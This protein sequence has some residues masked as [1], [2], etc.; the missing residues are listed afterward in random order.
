MARAAR[1]PWLLKLRPDDAAR[2]LARARAAWDYLA[3]RAPFGALCYHFYGCMG[4]V[5]ATEAVRP[6][7]E[8]A[9]ACYDS[10]GDQS[11]DERVWAAVELYAATG[12]AAFHSYFTQRHCPRYRRW[13]WQAL[14]FSYGPATVAYAQLAAAA[15][16]GEQGALAVD[17]LVA[18]RCLD[19]LAA[20]AR[21]HME[22]AKSNAYRLAVPARTFRIFGYGW[23]YPAEPA[24]HLLLAAAL[25]G[26]GNA[27][28]A[29]GW[30]ALAAQ[31]LHYLLGANPQGFSLISGLGARRYQNVVDEESVYDDIDPAWPGQSVGLASGFSWINSYGSALGAAFP[32]GI[33][34]PA[35]HRISDVFNVNTEFTVPIL[36]MTLGAV[37]ALA[38]DAARTPLP[39]PPNITLELSTSSG[40]APLSVA[41]S[42]F[43]QGDPRVVATVEYDFG[44]GGHSYQANPVHVY[45]E[46]GR[47]LYGS[48]TVVDRAGQ[49]VS[50]SFT[51]F[52]CWPEGSDPAPPPPS[53]LLL[54]ARVAHEADPTAW[55]GPLPPLLLATSL[56]E[57]PDDGGASVAATASGTIVASSANLAWQGVQ[58]A[59]QGAALRPVRYEDTATY[60]LLPAA[61]ATAGVAST[62]TAGAT[63]GASAATAGQV[64]LGAASGGLVLEAWLYVEKFLSYGRGN[65]PLLGIK[66]GTNRFFGL[67]GTIWS[68][69]MLV[70]GQQTLANDT[71]LA[72]RLTLGRWHHLK[73]SATSANASTSTSSNT[74][75]SAGSG[76]AQGQAQAFCRAWVDGVL[77]ARVAGCSSEEVFRYCGAAAGPLQLIV[78]S[79]KGYVDGLRVYAS[80][81]GDL[82]RLCGPRPP[83]PPPPRPPPPPAPDNRFYT[84]TPDRGTLALLDSD[85]AC[86]LT[87]RALAA[88]IPLR[89]FSGGAPSGIVL[90]PNTTTYA[91]GLSASPDGVPA[92][93]N[94]SNSSSSS[95]Q[96]GEV[97][98]TQWMQQPAGCS[99]R[100]GSQAVR[101]GSSGLAWE[102]PGSI[103]AAARAA[104]E[105][106]IDAKIFVEAWRT[107]YSLWNA[108][109]LGI[110]TNW[111]AYFKISYDMWTHAR[112]LLS[113][114]ATTTTAA[115]SSNSSTS[116]ISALQAFAGVLLNTSQ[117]EAA[118]S[119]GCWHHVALTAN[120]SGCALAVDGVELVAAAGCN[121]T[122][123]LPK[124]AGRA[125]LAVG[126]VR[127]WVDELRV[128]AVWRRTQRPGDFQWSPPPPPPPP[129]PP[130]LPS[131]PSPPR[132]PAPRPPPPPP[133]PKPRSPSPPPPRPPLPPPPRPPPPRPPP[134]SLSS[135]PPKPLP[136]TPPRPSTSPPPP[137]PRPPPRQPPQPSP[138]SAPHPPSPAPLPPPPSPAPP[139][140]PLPPAL[141]LLDSTTLLLLGPSATSCSAANITTNN[142]A[143]A[144]NAIAAAYLLSNSSS[145]L[146]AERYS[147]G[148][149]AGVLA[150]STVGSPVLLSALGGVGQPPSFAGHSGGCVLWLNHSSCG[151]CAY[152]K[153]E[154][155]TAAMAAVKAAG[156]MTID[157]KL[158]VTKWVNYAIDNS[159]PLLGW[160]QAWDR[161]FKLTSDKYQMVRALVSAP[162]TVTTQQGLYGGE[163]VKWPLLNP[164]LSPGAWH[165]VALTVNSSA[166]GLYVDGA[167]MNGTTVPCNVTAMAN[168]GSVATVTVGGFQGYVADLRLSAGWGVTSRPVPL[169]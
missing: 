142:N 83:P 86:G 57:G 154:V 1:S 162:S 66:Q 77:V 26:G 75:S 85:S 157:A 113:T 165:H 146:L 34:Y 149:S 58:P 123:L 8:K 3:A 168:W 92:S 126:G 135:P 167:L 44:D 112:V 10:K 43:I 136:P 47:A 151:S 56:A 2:Y 156:A 128:S 125:V 105:F 36:A 16:S 4:T 27:S 73:L 78:G 21:G 52:T 88:A 104:G 65:T 124:P 164:A 166:C 163:F 110:S 20:V 68:G 141:S 138:P 119:A 30:R 18:Q 55:G 23:H 60:T 98:N 29:A 11:H 159:D 137:P 89:L 129:P 108:D 143:A 74:S 96:A 122:R 131:P 140:P 69:N 54:A 62:A 121:A 103:L 72:P 94:S 12:E 134:Q 5:D 70:A 81:D 46:A 33:D 161:Y 144:T 50:K 139:L 150:P 45:G 152:V 38:G 13:G 32:P 42:L 61:G 17:P 91:A 59:W 117:L 63:A 114:P 48:V 51:V 67:Q 53:G 148:M 31:Q 155:S 64:L 80:P 107:G 35:L 111:D 169:N 147:G 118:L 130:L 25:A 22:E 120:A 115:A 132:P 14:P 9:Y 90:L 15:G 37:V 24:L 106:A 133:V 153:Y 145:A 71:L 95:S 79:F 99:L 39:P 109:V 100:L 158:W 19:E 127:G 93:N 87:G 6:A 49:A 101:N 116:S 160:Q 97:G 28:E 102:L 41:F 76:Q 40:P 82:D 84:V 7:W